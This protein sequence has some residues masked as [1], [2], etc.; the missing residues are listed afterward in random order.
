MRAEVARLDPPT[1]P[2]DGAAR[3]RALFVEKGGRARGWI[4]RLGSMPRTAK[5]RP[6]QYDCSRCPAYCCSI[7]SAVQVTSRDVRRLAAHFDLDV[8]D[9]KARYTRVRSGERELVR[10]PDPVLGQ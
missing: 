4:P 1:E 9:A 8:E 5:K 7:Y 3:P 10:K 6:E 2:G